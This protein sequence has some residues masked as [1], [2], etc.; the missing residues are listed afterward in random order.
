M[1]SLKRR[2]SNLKEANLPN[3]KETAKKYGH[4]EIIKLFYNENKYLPSPKVRESIKINSPN[5]YPEY[6]EPM[7]IEKLSDVFQ[8]DSSYFYFSNGS[9]AILDCIPTLFASKTNKNNIVLPE[10]TFGRIETTALVND[11][12]VKKVQLDDG[13]INLDKM[14]EAIDSKTSIIYVVNP[15][16]PTGKLNSHENIINFLENVP[17]N[18]LVVIDEAYGE[19]AFGIKE[20]YENNK[21]IIDKFDNVIITHTFSKLYAL[22]SFRVG[23]MISRPYI[24]NLFRKA[25]QYL[26][27]NKY[28]LQ[29]ALA[30]FSD[31]N[32]YDQIVK[33]NN[34]EKEK[35]YATFEELKIKYYKSFG[36]FVYL[37][38]DD[39]KSF[40]EFL[41]SKYGVLIRSIRN[42]AIRI[43]I[44]TPEEND[45]VIKAL[46]EYYV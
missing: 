39:N 21:E 11:I 15:N 28:S 34:E 37:F 46:K 22:A 33:K 14:L 38:V 42:N 17:N 9:D 6:K 20:N 27:I 24:V 12:E 13:L 30:A 45:I 2:F 26:P 23:Y 8:I 1:I 16:M 29:A 43:T 32:Y 44:G 36:N 19:Y 4:K 3:S 31:K 25:Y 40:E 41:V 10:L 7:L 35:Y 18:I 5:I